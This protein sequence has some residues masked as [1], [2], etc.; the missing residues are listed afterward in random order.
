M[1]AE[2]IAYHE[3]K[4]YQAHSEIMQPRFFGEVDLSSLGADAKVKSLPIYH[5]KLRHAGMPDR[6]IYSTRFAGLDFEAVS[7]PGLERLILTQIKAL[8]RFERLPEYIFQVGNNAWPIYQIHDQLLTRYPG[9][10]VFNAS[11]ISNLRIWLAEHFKQMGRISHRRE[12][13]LLF[14]AN[15]DLQLYAPYCVLRV[16][17]E[18]TPDIPIFPFP[19]DNGLRLVA[20]LNRKS[21]TAPFNQARGI[22]TL[23]TAVGGYW[24]EQGLLNSPLE[25][26]I[27]KLPVNSWKKVK[28]S[29]CLSEYSLSYTR[30]R[31]G[32]RQPQTLPVYEDGGI[33]KAARVNRVGRVVIYTAADLQTLARRVGQDL[34]FYGA[35]EDA[36]AVEVNSDN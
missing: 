32:V 12:M 16:P 19:G 2:I 36:N 22:F 5:H 25:S 14:L 30:L 4:T 31:D 35:L 10:P 27:R 34:S 7:L 11:D 23:Q 9:G 21:V 6:F 18:I 1:P 33:L 28:E 29:F 15:Y 13:E 24:A 8:I 26:T 20:P 17:G 3:N